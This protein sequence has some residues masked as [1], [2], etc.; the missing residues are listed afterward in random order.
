MIHRRTVL[1]GLA[2]AMAGPALAQVPTNPDVVVVG[3]G[4][5]GL[6]AARELTRNG[7]SVAVVEARSRIGGRAF[8]ES[9]TFGVPYDHGC[10]WLHSADVNP[11]TALVER[12]AKFQ[13]IDEG[14]RDSWIFLDGHEASDGDYDLFDE[15][16]DALVERIESAEGDLKRRGDRSLSAFLKPSDRIGRLAMEANARQYGLDP[17]EISLA[18]VYG[19]IETGDERMVP[20]GMGAALMAILG[21]S[22]PV[23]LETV[24]SGIDWSGRTVT[25]D[26]SKGRI[27]AKAALVTVPV[28]VLATSAIRFTPELPDWKRAAIAG[29]RMATLEKIALQFDG[30]PFD[31][32]ADTTTC[33]VQQGAEG[34]VWE[35]PLRPFGLPMAIGFIGGAQSDALGRS[36]VPGA[37]AESA[38]IAALESAFGSRVRGTLRRSHLTRWTVDPYARGSYSATRIGAADKRVDLQRPVGDR[39]FFAGEAMGGPWATQAAGAYV[40]AQAAVRG[41]VQSLR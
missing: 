3:A 17:G 41:I 12:E 35:F 31:D 15:R 36:K 5:A 20:K 1:A 10:A 21:G 13:T 34:Y 6:T 33:Y 32:E 2:T 16:M 19:Q 26:T 18:D 11:L 40:S 29:L 8:T 4:V 28:G 37:A 7:V 22:L 27:T 14:D 9:K 25:V 39:V 23:S 24:V 30:N 38:A